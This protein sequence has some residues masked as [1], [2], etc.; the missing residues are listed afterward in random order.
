M[1]LTDKKIL[2]VHKIKLLEKQNKFKE[3]SKLA[4]KYL[5]DTYFLKETIFTCQSC[6]NTH[7]EPLGRC[8]KCNEWGQYL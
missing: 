3:S 6:S 4:V 5:N 8:P 1:D 7:D 2:I